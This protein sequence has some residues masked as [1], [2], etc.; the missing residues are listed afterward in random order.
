MSFHIYSGSF[1]TKGTA[2]IQGLRGTLIKNEGDYGD[3]PLISPTYVARELLDF[4]DGLAQGFD[5]QR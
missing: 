4:G 3:N 5:E 2:R 1:Q